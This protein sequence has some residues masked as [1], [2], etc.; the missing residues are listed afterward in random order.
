[1]RPACIVWRVLSHIVSKAPA[2]IVWIVLSRIV[3]KAPRL[4]RL[5]SALLHSPECALSASPFGS[6]PYLKNID[7]ISL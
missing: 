6:D 5:E 2:C 4:H 3:R 1:M 7:E